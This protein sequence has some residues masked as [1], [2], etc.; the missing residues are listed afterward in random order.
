M[1]I[2][3]NDPKLI[4]LCLLRPALSERRY[5]LTIIKYFMKNFFRD[6]PIEP[7]KVQQCENCTNTIKTAI[8]EHAI[9]SATDASGKIIF[10]NKKFCETS[11]YSEEELIGQNHRIIN[12]GYHPKE[13][14]AE[15]WKTIK[16]GK[17][18]QGEFCNRAKDGSLYW[19]SATIVP[20]FD[21]HGE[22]YQFIGIRTDITAQK[23]AQSKE[24]EL[25]LALRQQ[26]EELR[27][28]KEAA[29]AANQMKGQ[30]LAN[31][32]HEIRTPL[33]SIIGFAE[34]L[35][36]D[37]LSDRERSDAVLRIVSNG[38][39]LLELINN[40]LDIAKI[41]S[42]A[43][44]FETRPYSPYHLALEVMDMLKP[45]LLEK[46]LALRISPCWPLPKH[47][48][49]DPLRIKQ[50]LLNITSNAVKFTDKGD[51]EIQIDYDPATH[52]IE[53]R[54]RDSGIGLTAEQQ[55]R[56]F[57]PF[58]QADASTTRRYGGT[59]LGL[60]I[61]RRLVERMNGVLSVSSTIGQGSTFTCR[62]PSGTLDEVTFFS[63]E[64]RPRLNEQIS[65]PKETKPLRGRVLIADDAKDNCELLALLMRRSGV[66][67]FFAHD[68]A[69]ALDL[70][71]SQTFDL[72]FMDM[73]M[74]TMDG[75]TA[76]RTLRETGNTT[77]IVALTADV[78]TRDIELCL[79]AGC[80]EHLGKP[81]RQE[82]LINLL[83][84]YLASLDPRDPQDDSQTEGLF[85]LHDPEFV[86]L[87]SNFVMSLDGRL[88]AL[89]AAV[90]AGDIRQTG[91]LA[92]SLK[93][94]ASLYCFPDLREAAVRVEALACA[95]EFSEMPHAMEIV[96]R[97]CA[98]LERGMASRAAL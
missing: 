82:A 15:F 19:V 60:A 6:V 97:S 37:N 2:I 33:T 10:A 45:R 31:M 69:Q 40:I 13:Y 18:W 58:T 47:I 49:G 88:A 26:S 93:G 17:V 25:H 79:A 78:M 87:R 38:N 90:R 46:G 67:L 32:S 1:A 51:I 75:Y 52:T 34:T 16:S 72:I 50:I 55:S 41:D 86:Q 29:E 98:E 5:K 70:C 23:L 66:Q 8:D 85:P 77:P 62:L 28:A 4:D 65:P 3:Q 83:H 63:D 22:I 94:S 7:G 59:G 14:I 64:N 74:P 20:F 48:S 30:F 56:L 96:T 27:L 80:N 95:G 89:Q 44:T 71:S 11:K 84:R 91:E 76:T 36:L 73:H 92:H 24:H 81:F 12:S 42:G 21:A 54:V 9:V 35:Q 61:S 68:G 39:H 43:L 57:I 53:Y